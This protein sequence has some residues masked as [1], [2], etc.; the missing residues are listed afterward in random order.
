MLRPDEV[1]IDQRIRF[2]YRNYTNVMSIRDVTPTNVYFGENRWYRGKQ[3]LMDGWDHEK[4]TTRC[5]ALKDVWLYHDQDIL[6]WLEELMSSGASGLKSH[7][8]TLNERIVSLDNQLRIVTDEIIRKDEALAN[9]KD[10]VLR[11]EEDERAALAKVKQLEQHIASYPISPAPALPDPRK[12][13]FISFKSFRPSSSVDQDRV[14][15]EDSFSESQSEEAQVLSMSDFNPAVTEDTLPKDDSFSDEE[16]DS[17]ADA[18]EIP[19]PAEAAE[20]LKMPQPELPDRLVLKPEERQVTHEEAVHRLGVVLRGNDSLRQARD[21]FPNGSVVVYEPAESYGPVQTSAVPW[22]LEDGTIVTRLVGIDGWVEV[23]AL[24][25]ASFKE[26][27]AY[28]EQKLRGIKASPYDNNGINFR[29]GRI[30][31]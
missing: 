24:R 27:A 20:V 9:L 21:Q 16:L 8:N 29:K 15:G 17:I 18:M 1:V 7:I 3:W 22:E 19:F 28:G 12:D 10:Y 6:E 14:P 23:A 25:S 31:D 5:F 11:L 30:D 26:A 13:P 2:L 4:D